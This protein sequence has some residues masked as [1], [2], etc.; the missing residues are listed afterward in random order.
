[1]RSILEDAAR[2]VPARAPL[3][4]EMMARAARR[5]SVDVEPQK[6]RVAASD[7]LSEQ[8]RA[9]IKAMVAEAFRL[10]R[11]ET[12]DDTSD[13]IGFGEPDERFCNRIAAVKP[14]LFAQ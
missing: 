13:E 7:G 2:L 6:P 12:R 4:A 9:E 3:V 8:R 1:V 5:E 11:E 14:P 10:A